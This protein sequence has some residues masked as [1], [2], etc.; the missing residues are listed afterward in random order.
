MLVCQVREVSNTHQTPSHH[1]VRDPPWTHFSRRIHSQPQNFLIWPTER[2]T[3]TFHR[4]T[5]S[6]HLVRDPSWT[7]FSTR[8]HSQT[9]NFLI[10]STEC[11]T[12]T[13]SQNPL[14]SPGRRHLPGLFFKGNPFPNSEFPYLAQKGYFNRKIRFLHFPLS[15]GCSMGGK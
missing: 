2:A 9:Q 13:F 1:P 11:A 6:D 8:I 10:W 4:I 15:M 12:A 7:H 14:K 5:L 3:A